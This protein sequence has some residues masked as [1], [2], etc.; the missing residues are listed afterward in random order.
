MKLKDVV[1]LMRSKL[2]IHPELIGW[3]GVIDYQPSRRRMGQCRFR[4]REVGI[5]A[6]YAEQHADDMVLDTILHEIAHAL[7]WERHH[8]SGHG[9]MW[10]SICREIGAKP[11]RLVSGVQYRVA[12]YAAVCPK[13]G[14]ILYRDRKPKAGQ[15]RVHS[16]CLPN[17][18]RE[19]YQIYALKWGVNPDYVMEVSNSVAKRTEGVVTDVTSDEVQLLL[20]RLAIAHG[21]EAKNIRAKLRRLGHRGGLN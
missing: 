19:Q 7:C 4:R 14:N 13:C 11:E 15:V 2:V 8:V 20:R 10:K 16:T 5:T 17:V 9:R 21:K 6:W 3:K 18:A 1:E 12:R